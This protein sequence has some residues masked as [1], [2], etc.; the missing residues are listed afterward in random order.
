MIY[1]G[2]IAADGTQQRNDFQDRL[3][4]FFNGEPLPPK[5]TGDRDQGLTAKEAQSRKAAEDAAILSA[6]DEI[7]LG[8]GTAAEA[9]AESI[10]PRFSM[11]P[12][13][14]THDDDELPEKIYVKPILVSPYDRAFL[15][16][17]ALESEL[18]S[19]Q[20]DDRPQIE[21]DLVAAN[22]KWDI[23]KNRDLD[24]RYRQFHLIDQHRAG[25]G[26]ED[27]NTSRRNVRD[28]PN[29]SLKEMSAEEQQAHRK[30][31]KAASA[32]KSRA[33]A[34]QFPGQKIKPNDIP[35]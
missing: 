21:A 7:M 9:L 28:Q 30:A 16:V 6:M 14:M 17:R 25:E 35:Y 19:A 15:K 20:A 1:S 5:D 4:H 23:E 26:R 32:R 2:I 10:T 13:F 12:N 33:K 24:D 27:R 8:D 34:K 11:D 22:V 29:A 31:Q 3:D 18:A